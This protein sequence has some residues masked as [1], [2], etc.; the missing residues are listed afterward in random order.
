MLILEYLVNGLLFGATYSLV[1]IGFTLIF[2]VLN[3]L[4]IAHGATIMAS[5]FAGAYVSLRLG[6][7]NSY[8]VLGL[9]FAASVLSGAIIGVL[10]WFVAFAP[11]RNASPLA[12]FVTSAAVTL[13]LEETF[14]LIS[15]KVPE[16][17][18][19]FSP[20]PSKLEDL[21][22]LVGPVLVRGAYVVI[23]IVAVILMIVLHW[24][25]SR[26][27]M[28]RA[29]RAVEENPT[30]AWL[31]GINV[32]RVEITV[33]AV[34]SAIAGAAGCLIGVSMG[35]VG[36]FM[37]AHLLLT[38][39]VII[40]LAGLGSL[41]GAMVCGLIVGV[42]EMT[43]VGLVSASVKE[44]VLF[45]ILFAVLVVRPQGLFSGPQVRRD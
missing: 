27:N 25:I 22:I 43:I 21:V 1:A 35:T 10:V 9:S 18:P 39:F 38:G 12:P 28:G 45:I 41:Y 30:V 32:R 33:F 11:L 34:A 3:R 36:P 40:V 24:W 5:A 26:S 29:I 7:A 23:F 44:A 20:F 8:A 15:R 37:G 14:L 42:I 19:E 6:G 4:N 31:L 16:F 2:G 13:I 17:S